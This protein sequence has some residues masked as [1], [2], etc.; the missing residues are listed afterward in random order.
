MNGPGDDIPRGGESEALRAQLSVLRDEPLDEAG[1]HQS[2]HLRLALA[3]PPEPPGMRRL[4]R[5][6]A[7]VLWPLSGA[8]A[9][10]LAF[11]LTG[12]VAAPAASVPEMA[13]PVIAAAVVAPPERPGSV[14]PASKVAVLKLDFTVDVAVEDAE[15]EVSLPEGLAFWV[16]G[17]AVEERA[18]TWRQPLREG[19]NVVPVAVRGKAPGRYTVCARARVDGRDIV[20]DVV[21]E[22]TAG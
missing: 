2:L 3:G 18:F 10:V 22:V 19:S 12:K 6:F 15:F 21:L 20:H 11:L 16:G 4:L 8:L 13:A 7:P 1:F 17:E 9:G 5:R 14:V